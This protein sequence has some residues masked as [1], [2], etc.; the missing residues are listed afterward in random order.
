LVYQPGL[1]W[2]DTRHA[3]NEGKT[4]SNI[5]SEYMKKR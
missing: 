5:Y 4:Q 2:Y 1:D 3:C